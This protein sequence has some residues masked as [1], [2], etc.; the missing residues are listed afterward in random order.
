MEVFT[1]AEG[2]LVIHGVECNK[3][4]NK[5]IILAIHGWQDNCASFFPLAEHLS[6]FHV[7]MIDLPGHGLSE[8]RHNT[9]HYYFVDYI[10]DIYHVINQKFNK[11]VH[12]LG[13]SMGAM[14][15]SLYA[16]C[17]AESV[18]SINMIDGLGFVTTDETDV[19][20]QLKSAILQRQR[21]NKKTKRVY[22][23]FDS[24]VNA[25][26]Y[27]SDLNYEQSKLLMARASKESNEGYELLTDPRLKYH[28][29]FR[30]SEQQAKEIC[31]RINVPSLLI[32]A[33]NSHLQIKKTIEKFQPYYDN[34]MQFEI[35]GGHHCHMQKPETV[36]KYIKHFIS[37]KTL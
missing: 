8:W 7:V 6:D 9:A 18:K 12:L 15:I 21:N 10:E 4:Q 14:A 30:Y 3:N 31:K 5:E 19:V 17:F 2:D 29:G 11:P 35:A 36:A 32:K 25:R 13:H 26:M 24:L 1:I 37:T 23:D 20:S 16:A 28:S 22:K 34:L 27:G 33:Q